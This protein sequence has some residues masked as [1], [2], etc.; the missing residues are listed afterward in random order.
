MITQDK[1][2]IY[3]K[4]TGNSEKWLQ[5]SDIFEKYGIDAGDWPMIKE[6]LEELAVIKSGSLTQHQINE[7]KRKMQEQVDCDPTLKLLFEIA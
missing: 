6:L 3:Q 4:F 7:L 5:S 1:V 2:H